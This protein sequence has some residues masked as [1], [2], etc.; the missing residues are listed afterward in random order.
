MA[1]QWIIQTTLSSQ[2]ATQ[3]SAV[4]HRSWKN[5]LN[6][7]LLS[8]R[9]MQML[10]LIM[11]ATVTIVILNGCDAFTAILPTDNSHVQ[12]P[13]C[14]TID[15]ILPT[16][17]SMKPVTTITGTDPTTKPNYENI[18]G[19]FGPLVDQFCMTIFRNKLRDQVMMSYFDM[20][21]T[22]V[23]NNND[24]ISTNTVPA[25]P[26]Y[27]GAANF[28]QIVKLAAAMNSLYTNPKRIQHRAQNVLSSLFPSWLPKQYKK[29]FSKPFPIF[30]ARMNARVTAVLGVWL[31]GE[32]TV[33]DIV[34]SVPEQL[35]HTLSVDGT[36]YF[37]TTT[38]IGKNQ[39][40]LVTRCRFLEE[41]QCASVCVNSCK[42]PTQNFFLQ[43]MGIPLLMEPN[44]EDGSC[45]FSF[46][47]YPNTTT[48]NIATSTPCLS[49]CPTAGS[50]RRN[51]NN[52][53][54]I[55]SSLTTTV[56]TAKCSMMG[57]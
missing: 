31:M 33:N 37:S 32:C 46:G 11:V 43:Q 36:S 23:T 9:F 45:Q 12:S 48:E 4:Y 41:S 7:R 47:R 5:H 50:F 24:A 52:V 42:I 21:T 28:T 57:D 20:D 14:R 39:G 44:Y 18:V 55:R 16:L 40:V 51:H 53:N 19:P 8:I 25:D 27:Y 3:L 56:D 22:S 6:Q 1:L 35:N 34:I 38:V 10:R 15:R 2:R 54:N 30:S 49:R 13:R 29:L 17:H 26:M